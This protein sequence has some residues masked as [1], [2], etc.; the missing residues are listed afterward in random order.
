MSGEFRVSLPQLPQ[1]YFLKHWEWKDKHSSVFTL[2]AALFHFPTIL[3][4][5]Y[6]MAVLVSQG[7]P[8]FPWMWMAK[9]ARK[10]F[11]GC[12]CK[13]KDLT[14]IFHVKHPNHSTHNSVQGEILNVMICKVFT[15]WCLKWNPPKKLKWVLAIPSSQTEM[16]F[17][18]VFL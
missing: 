5:I 14:R 17:F 18:K 1:G 3:K 16:I 11:L 12:L 15:V 4:E 7:E 10:W 9:K 6:M 13:A 2:F 8:S